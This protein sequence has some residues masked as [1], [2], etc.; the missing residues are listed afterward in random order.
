MDTVMI[1]G[2]QP[3]QESAG[4]DVESGS[5]KELSEL[6]RKKVVTMRLAVLASARLIAQVRW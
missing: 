4:V 6:P 2:W 1:L 3:K 5:L